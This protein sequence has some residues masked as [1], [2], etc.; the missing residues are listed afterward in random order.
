MPIPFFPVLGLPDSPLLL[1]LTGTFTPLFAGLVLLTSLCG[2]GIGILIARAGTA[3]EVTS[4]E[5]DTTTPHL[6]KAA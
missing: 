2:L 1:D 6:P 5:F 4:R 3:R